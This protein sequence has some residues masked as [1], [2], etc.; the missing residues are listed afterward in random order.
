MSNGI[1]E[2]RL[3]GRFLKHVELVE[4]VKAVV[5]EEQVVVEEP[6]MLQGLGDMIREQPGEMMD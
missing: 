4:V 1:P 5:D 6:P 3:G 2:I